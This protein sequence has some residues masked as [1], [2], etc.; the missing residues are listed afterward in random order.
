MKK[1]HIAVTF[2]YIQHQNTRIEE[3][4]AVLL[5]GQYKAVKKIEGGFTSIKYM[6]THVEGYQIGLQ[7]FEQFNNLRNRLPN[8]FRRLEF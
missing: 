2:D 1:Y 5:G 6:L 7:L 3:F 4:V 8:D